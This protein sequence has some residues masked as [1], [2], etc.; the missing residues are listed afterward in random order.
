MPPKSQPSDAPAPQSRT[1]RSTPSAKQVRFPM[2]RSKVRGQTKAAQ[3]RDKNASLKQQT[4]TQMDFV[5]SF[6]EE[7]TLSDSDEASDDAFSSPEKPVIHQKTSLEA[8]SKDKEEEETVGDTPVIQDSYASPDDSLSPLKLQPIQLRNVVP[9]PSRVRGTPPLDTVKASPRRRAHWSSNL[10]GSKR[11][12]PS[13][14]DD[15][16]SPT[17]VRFLPAK[18][19]D[20]REIPDSDEE[21]EELELLEEDQV[22]LQETFATGQETQLVLEE[23][24][25]LES[26]EQREQGPSAVPSQVSP[27]TATSSGASLHNKPVP[28]IETTNPLPTTK[29]PSQSP[30]TSPSPSP[31]PT[32]ESHR[33]TD[34]SQSPHD[35]IFESQRVPL[36]ILQSF[37]PVSARTDIL[38]PIPSKVLASLING[39]EP[40]LHLPYRLPQLVARFWLLDQETLR[41]MACVQPGE[42]SGP[43]WDYHVDQVY[44]LNNPVEE[45]DMQEEG[46][47]TGQV[48]R[49]IYLPPAIVGQL[50]WNLRCATFD[51]TGQE[52]HDDGNSAVEA[53]D[54][55]S[56]ESSMPLH[57]AAHSG[58]RSTTHDAGQPSSLLFQDHGS[59]LATL[60]ANAVFDSSPLLTKSQMLSDSLLSDDV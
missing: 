4:L 47:V 37:T 14:E 19:V 24:A 5:S 15:V 48:R 52:E 21:Y 56:P 17:R 40:L 35:Q 36:H 13:Q 38:L 53:L 33:Q 46:W 9:S 1:Y 30:T 22:V 59:S 23:L 58:S 26:P 11:L 8:Q 27:S 54:S 7:V 50:L 25:S 20:D 31:N 49:Y 6:S 12:K 10:G 60:P 43:N 32:S 2:S 34:L 42:P 18:D 55:R 44:E 51:R 28:P 39:S 57:P 29:A 16:P 41:Y 45:R 3:K